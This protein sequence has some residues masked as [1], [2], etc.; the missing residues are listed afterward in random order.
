MASNIPVVF[1][2]EDRFSFEFTA[3]EKQGFTDKILS[4]KW[5]EAYP[6]IFD[7][8]DLRIALSQPTYHFY[9]WFTAVTI[10]QQTGMLSLVEQYE[11]RNHKRK[12]KV[13]RAI[14]DAKL[15][16]AI[17]GREK[18]GAQGPDLLVYAPDFS[19]WFFCEVKGPGDSLKPKQC[20]RFTNICE[21]TSKPIA[22]ARV[23]RT[24]N[25]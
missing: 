4:N 13:M 9:E 17:D 20:L 22:L 24:R 2:F 6:D 8:D 19:N 3:K 5:R 15:F 7:D 10:F 12:W 23:V 25:K 1:S 21:I 11:F 16:A 14:N 18:F